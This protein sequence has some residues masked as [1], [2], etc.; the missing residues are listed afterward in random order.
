[1]KQSGQR[2]QECCSIGIMYQ[3]D[4]TNISFLCWGLIIKLNLY[5]T[6]HY[7]QFEHK[8]IQNINMHRK[9]KYV[10]MR[11]RDVG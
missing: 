9:Y 4:D 2:W 11:K 10:K 1:M 8:F 6:N 7:S 5:D 3:E